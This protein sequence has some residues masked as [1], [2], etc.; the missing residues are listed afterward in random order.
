MMYQSQLFG[1]PCSNC[2]TLMAAHCRV[3]TIPCCPRYPQHIEAKDATLDVERLAL[4]MMN[5]LPDILDWEMHTDAIAA[6]YARLGE[7]IEPLTNVRDASGKRYTDTELTALVD[8]A[9]DIDPRGRPSSPTV[10][11]KDEP[12]G[13]WSAQFHNT[14]LRGGPGDGLLIAMA[15]TTHTIVWDSPWRPPEP[16]EYRRT[17]DVEA[18]RAVFQWHGWE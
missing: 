7:P 5:T 6:E 16:G 18:G 17:D 14:I 11:P 4:A 13:G 8:L 10:E 2:Q 15:E 12:D 3:H 9:D 1:L